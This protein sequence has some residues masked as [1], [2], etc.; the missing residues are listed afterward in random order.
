MFFAE[1][2]VKAVDELKERIT[3]LEVENA[4]LRAAQDRQ[5]QEGK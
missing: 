1:D 5:K 3:Q 4:E 2:I